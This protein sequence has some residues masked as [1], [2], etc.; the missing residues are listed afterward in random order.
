MGRVSLQDL[1]IL[2][3]LLTPALLLLLQPQGPHCRACTQLRIQR[4]QFSSRQ[5]EGA[6]TKLLFSEESG[7]VCGEENA[8]EASLTTAS[9]APDADCGEQG[10][11]L[12]SEDEKR[13]SLVCEWRQLEAFVEALNSERFSATLI[14]NASTKAV[15]KISSVRS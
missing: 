13:F 1:A 14:W 4:I 8:S 5:R 7:S 11:S 12:K 10:E 9:E 3:Q 6:E 2:A 15:L